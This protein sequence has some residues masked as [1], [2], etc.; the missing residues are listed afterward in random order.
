MITRS[1]QNSHA[2][3]RHTSGEAT[4]CL[5][6]TTQSSGGKLEILLA[7]LLTFVLSFLFAMLDL[8]R[9]NFYLAL[10]LFL[11]ISIFLVVIMFRSLMKRVLIVFPNKS[12]LLKRSV[13]GFVTSKTLDLTGGYISVENQA[14]YDDRIIK[15]EGTRI[16]FDLV[17]YDIA[18]TPLEIGAYGREA[19]ANEVK[20]KIERYLGMDQPDAK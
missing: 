15:I 5:Q 4:S 9:V 16:L 18:G 3:D 19:Q 14:E 12:L 11:V 6:L 1:L 13:F 8:S 20:R 10:A 17:A 2:Q 7:C